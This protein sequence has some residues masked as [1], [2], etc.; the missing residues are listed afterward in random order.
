MKTFTLD[1]IVREYMIQRGDEMVNRSYARLYQLA[2]L[3]LRDIY[4]DKP[5]ANKEIPLDVNED[6]TVTL[7]N[8]FIKLRRLYII[9][10]G[11]RIAIGLNENMALPTKNDCGDDVVDQPS[12]DTTPAWIYPFYGIEYT[13]FGVG[14]S[15]NKYGYYRIF[16][17]LGYIALQ[18]NIDFDSVVMEYEADIETVGDDYVVAPYDVEALKAWIFWKDIQFN[19]RMTQQ[20]LVAK[21]EYQLEKLRAAKRHNALNAPDMIRAIKSGFMSAP[22]I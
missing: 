22:K 5:V 7:P 2:V 15:F 14:G 6:H 12:D 18:M 13:Q 1:S 4:H 19:K 10:A 20:A 8:D 21:R 9:A 11:Q 3:G 17:E 16:P